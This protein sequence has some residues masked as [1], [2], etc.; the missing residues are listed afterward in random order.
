MSKYFIG[1]IG[2]NTKKDCENYTRNIL[3]E[4]GFNEIRNTHKH[5]EFFN[6]LIKNHPDYETKKGPGINYFYITP[7][8]M[9]RKY[10]E[11]RIKRLDNSDIDISWRYC[12]E[13]KIRTNYYYLTQAMRTVIRDDI[14]VYKQQ[15][16][17]KH[18]LFCNYC[19]NRNESYENYHVDHDNPSFQE[20]KDN[21]LRINT[22]NIPNLFADYKK[23]NLTTFRKEDKQFE[24]AWITYHNQNCNLQ[25]LCRNCNLTK[26]N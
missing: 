17:R 1:D 6:N 9:N 5:F 8:R 15:Q 2:F 24:N 11:L 13:F 3:N 4:I 20:L 10:K 7:N 12:C 26:P 19:Q 23:F 18:G 14:I 21:F 16:Q 25:I 22:H